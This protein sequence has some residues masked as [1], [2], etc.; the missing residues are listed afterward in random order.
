MTVSKSATTGFFA[1]VVG[2][3]RGVLLVVAA[4]A[5]GVGVFLRVVLVSTGSGSGSGSVRW[6]TCTWTVSAY[7]GDYETCRGESA[8][9]S[10]PGC[11]HSDSDSN[12]NS[13][14]EKAWRDVEEGRDACLT[15]E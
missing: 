5:V 13:E 15:E 11:T 1:A 8:A 6:V 4:A 3:D 10:D 14:T 9:D 12:A 7:F 2:T